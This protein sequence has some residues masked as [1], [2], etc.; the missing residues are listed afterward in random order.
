MR[1][2]EF[3]VIMVVVVCLILSALCAGCQPVTA[4]Y[5]GRQRTAAQI[6]AEVAAKVKAAAAAEALETAKAKLDAERLQRAAEAEARAAE[7]QA[8]REQQQAARIYASNLRKVAMQ[9]ENARAELEER[10]AEMNEHISGTLATRHDAATVGLADGLANI[11]TALDASRVQRESAITGMRSMAEAALADI[12]A[13]EEARGALVNFA[14]GVIGDPA[15]SAA[16]SAVPGGGLISTILTGGLAL[17]GGVALRGMG[18][19]ARHDASWQDG[20]DTAKAEA[21]AK[22][23]AADKAWEEAQKEMRLQLAELQ[24]RVNG[25]AA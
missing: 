7:E 6:E 25:K 12:A 24:A 19:K 21:D 22:A 15:V 8:K 5:E 18:S 10:L 3:Y 4:E 1:L 14:Q 23:L 20:F 13:K 2:R 11:A 17:L 9:S 16:V